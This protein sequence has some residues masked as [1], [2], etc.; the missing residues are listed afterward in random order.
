M[1]PTQEPLK[2]ILRSTLPWHR[3]D[4]GKTECGRPAAEMAEGLILT[5]DEAVALW[6]R[7]GAQR[8]AFVLCST[9]CSTAN[10][11]PT[12]EESPIEVM[13]RHFGQR[14]W[15]G[16]DDA[17]LRRSAEREL[18]AIAML[19]DAHGNEFQAL[20]EGLADTGD[21]TARRQAKAAERQYMRRPR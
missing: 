19:I 16:R 3:D 10:R 21:L 18:H 2:H 7:W 9:C 12:W 4:A 20:I 6:K 11:H 14:V 8:A 17:E 1:T 13:T 5:R 15:V